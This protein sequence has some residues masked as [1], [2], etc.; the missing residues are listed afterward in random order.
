VLLIFIDDIQAVVRG[1]PVDDDVFKVSIFLIQ[2]GQY[3]FFQET[4]LV[5]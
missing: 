2:Y 5:V 1:A 3:G 4:V